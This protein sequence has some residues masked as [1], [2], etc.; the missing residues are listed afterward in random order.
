MGVEAQLRSSAVVPMTGLIM[1]GL[2]AYR[3]VAGPGP[4]HAGPWFAVGVAGAG[5]ML[6]GFPRLQRARA[7]QPDVSWFG[8]LWGELVAV[9]VSAVWLTVWASLSDEQRDAVMRNV[10]E[11]F[12]LVH[13]A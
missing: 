1:L 8:L 12:E 5:L 6:W 9:C 13:V 11:A 2:A 7:S 10:R 4:G 3:L